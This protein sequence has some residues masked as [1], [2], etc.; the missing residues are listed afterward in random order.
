MRRADAHRTYRRFGVHTALVIE[1]TSLRALCHHDRGLTV[2]AKEF[3]DLIARIVSASSR[4]NAMKGV[5]GGALAGVGVAA[6]ADAKNKN[7]GRGRKHGKGK[8]RK[9]NG[10][11][12][13]RGV[14][15]ETNAHNGKRTLCLCRDESTTTAT[16][17]TST[18]T[19]VTTSS[20]T[21]PIPRQYRALV[22]ETRHLKTK[23]ARKA[24]RNNPGSYRGPCTDETTT[25][26][27]TS[28]TTVIT[29]TRNR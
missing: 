21:S 13:E 3:D 12:K 20:G 9:D 23:K 16:T 6:A 24:L 27:S 15:S 10:K 11:G 19:T 28:T 7:K 26:T 17:A 18:S 8:A 4:R 2:D 29:F 25:S 14:G 1:S 5:L 22:C